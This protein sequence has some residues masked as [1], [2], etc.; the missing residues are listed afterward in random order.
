MALIAVTI[1]AC[2]SS[3]VRSQA[4]KAD[5]NLRRLLMDGIGELVKSFGEVKAPAEK[6]EV[7]SEYLPQ[8]FG[9]GV[10]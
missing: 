6:P 1:S 3:P 2:R 4:V 9:E 5:V 8:M 7:A 10:S